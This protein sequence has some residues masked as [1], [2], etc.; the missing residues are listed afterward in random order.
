[1]YKQT[2]FLTLLGLLLL[3][4]AVNAH[5]QVG[6]TANPQT[7]LRLKA[8]PGMGSF[9]TVR[10]A[11][12]VAQGFTISGSAV[13]VELGVPEHFEISLQPAT[14]YS[15][16]QRVARLPAT[17]WVRLVGSGKDNSYG[18]MVILGDFMENPFD[19]LPVMKPT[20]AITVP[21]QGFVK[22]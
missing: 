7:A 14:G 8:T 2:R 10:G 21:V 18:E 22:W 6:Q 11:A 20:V 17:V 1:M 12:S 3:G 13:G 15:S 4:G 19:D 5:A 9:S 16:S